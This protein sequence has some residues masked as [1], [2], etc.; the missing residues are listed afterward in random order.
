MSRNIGN[1]TSA[2]VTTMTIEERRILPGCTWSACAL[3]RALTLSSINAE[4]LSIPRNSYLR[5]L[6]H[7]CYRPRVQDSSFMHCSDIQRFLHGPIEISSTCSLPSLPR[8]PLP[9]LTS[10]TFGKTK[11]CAWQAWFASSG[12]GRKYS[13]Q[14][15]KL[16]NIT[17]WAAQKLSVR[18]GCE[19]FS[20][21]LGHF[22]TVVIIIPD[23]YL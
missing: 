4:L 22:G 2:L 15:A 11:R 23:S 13:T 20:M 9:N 14:R 3:R 7:I 17:S 19:V 5:L 1:T 16:V 21:V 18:Y 12:L 10:K 8:I 6:L